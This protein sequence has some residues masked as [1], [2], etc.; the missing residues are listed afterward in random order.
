M[1]KRQ[2]YDSDARLG[3]IQDP[4]VVGI[5]TSSLNSSNSSGSSSGGGGCFIA[6]AA[7]G[8]YMHPQV[9]ILRDFRDHSLLT[10]APGRSFVALYYRISPPLADFIARHELLRGVVR[11]AL[12]PVIF[13]VAY[14]AYAGAAFLLLAVLLSLSLRRRSHVGTAIN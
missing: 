4:L 13:A 5:D 14:P 2:S 7:F 6:T 12:G 11:V 9:K 1:Y 3:F 8:S 10:N